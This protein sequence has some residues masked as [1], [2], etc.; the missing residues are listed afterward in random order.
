[1]QAT[2]LG[3]YLFYGRAAD[4][5]AAG[6]AG[7][8]PGEAQLAGAGPTVPGR[9]RRRGR[10][11]QE[12][13]RAQPG[14]R[15]ARG[16]VGRR[17]RDP[18]PDS[19]RVLAVDGSRPADRRSARRRPRPVRVRARAGL[20]AATPRS[21]PTS[22]A[23]R[24]AARRR[25]ARCSGLLDAH[26]H[27][28]AFEFLGGRAH[29]GKPWDR[30]GVA[31]R[32][33]RLPR[34]LAATARARCSRTRSRT[35]TPRACTTRSAG[36]RSRTGR[37]ATSL[38]HEQTLLQVAR[39][40]LARRAAGVREPA[41]RQRGA[42]RGLSAAS[43]TRATRWTPC[44]WRR[45]DIRELQDYI[46][47]QYGGPGK[48]LFRIVTDP[49]EARQ[50]SSTRASS[51]WSWASRSRGC[52]TAGVYNDVPECDDAQI[53]RQLDEVY[54]LGVRDMELVNKF[55]NALGGRGG[56]QRHD[57]RDRQ[58]RQQARDRQVL[59][60]ADLHRATPER[61]RPRPAHVPGARRRDRSSARVLNALL[62]PR[63]ARR[64]IPTGAALQRARA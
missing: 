39:A 30:Y 5:M 46:D 58:Q 7:P 40:R 55:D 24:R 53:D 10:P 49:F 4:F 28:M 35:A 62:P 38:T 33:G 48:G 27:M 41:R 37:R 21:R 17:L 61:A 29:C 25:S 32:A 12:R 9:H 3:R 15:L 19:G 8:L 44:G 14:G 42:L 64:S 50:A 56:R 20:H 34:P 22:R 60:D 2:A 54:K 31:V 23:S 11:G 57:R 26:M 63:H 6:K 1:M 47:A 16:R 45:S 52:S 59:G 43:R 18:L 36:R 51:R 13:D